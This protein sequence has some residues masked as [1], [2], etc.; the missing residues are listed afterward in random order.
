MKNKKHKWDNI[1]LEG[2]PEPV[3]FMIALLIKGTFEHIAATTC[4]TKQLGGIQHIRIVQLSNNE[5]K[6]KT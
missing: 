5:K 1:N 4:K 2:I 6:K 3:A